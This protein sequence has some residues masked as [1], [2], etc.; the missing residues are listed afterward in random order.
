MRRASKDWSLKI[1]FRSFQRLGGLRYSLPP[2]SELGLERDFAICC[3]G[4]DPQGR[5]TM[6]DA[7]GQQQIRMGANSAVRNL[8]Y[9]R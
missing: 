8:L 7:E 1:D 2:Q 5:L 6:I 9:F 4:D 3:N